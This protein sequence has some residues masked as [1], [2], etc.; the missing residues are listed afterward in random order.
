MD[1]ITAIRQDKI[2]KRL[3]DGD[4]NITFDDALDNDMILNMGPQHPATHG[5]LR[6]LLRLEGET[7]L[8]CVPE[9]GYLH[10]GYEKL[11]ENV[12]YHEFIPHT[13]RLDYLSPMSN[14]TAIA[15][16]IENSL[17]IEASPRAQWIRV[18]VSEMARIS[19]HLMAMGAT[20]MDV[21][22]LTVL[23]WTFTER[24]KLYDIFELICGAR[25]TTSYT[26]IG[27][28]ANDINDATIEKLRDW[29]AQFPAQLEKSEKLVHRNSI[30]IKRVAGIGVISPELAVQY[31]LTGPCLRGSGI[32]RDIRR[33]MP[34]LVYDKLDF[35]VITY[36]EGDCWSR[37]MVRVDEM[38]ESI[39]IIT[40]VLDQMPKGPVLANEPK[41]V[42][43]RKNEI[44]TKMEELIHDF[45]LINF[46][47]APVPGET[48]TAIEAPKGELGF[49]IV[50]DGTGHPWKM[51]IR[52]PSASN[53]QALPHFV[54]G[55]ML[56][57]V[58]ACIGSID[59]VMGEADK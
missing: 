52:S 57:D 26:R 1:K 41:K 30:F 22:A 35:D 50:S 34:Y 48:Y 12:T 6:V 36:P 16:A 3:M 7:I 24:E 14:N 54:E 25:F 9:L 29:V 31:G 42:L 8:R 18:L 17:G 44:Y 59:P 51:K 53:L 58:V 19:S 15:L 2:Y 28:V 47:A 5:V 13:D 56:S 23:I 55:S 43:P 49:F 45:M 10:R 32:P 38:R 39:K 20:C 40:Q 21:G 37:Y 46:G 33:D 27:G 11:A 4:T